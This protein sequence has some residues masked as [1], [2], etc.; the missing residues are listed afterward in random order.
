MYVQKLEGTA[1]NKK[2]QQLLDF[3]SVVG[4]RE[5]TRAGVLELFAKLIARNNQVCLNMLKYR[6]N[7]P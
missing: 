2:R 6:K 7:N 4:P 3:K 5:L 1:Y